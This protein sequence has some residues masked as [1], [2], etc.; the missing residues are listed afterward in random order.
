MGKKK[1]ERERG[2]VGKKKRG[3]ERNHEREEKSLKL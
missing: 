1:R 3:I 2:K